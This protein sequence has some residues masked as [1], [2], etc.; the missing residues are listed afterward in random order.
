MGCSQ[1]KWCKSVFLSLDKYI[2]NCQLLIVKCNEIPLIHTNKNQT[3][4]FLK[5]KSANGIITS[6]NHTQYF[7]INGKIDLRHFSS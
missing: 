6:L 5:V 2:D 1:L 3:D 4:F 7:L